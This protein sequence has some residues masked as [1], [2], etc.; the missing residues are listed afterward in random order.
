M[1]PIE[2]VRPT[3]EVKYS[4]DQVNLGYLN[5]NVSFQIQIHMYCT[6]DVL[7][8]SL[9]SLLSLFRSLTCVR[10][11]IRHVQSHYIQANQRWPL[12]TH[13]ETFISSS[14]SAWWKRNMERSTIRQIRRSTFSSGLPVTVLVFKLKSL[15]LSS[16]SQTQRREEHFGSAKL[17]RP[18]FC[19][20]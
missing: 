18:S 15:T 10:V 7:R 3:K 12:R 9:V 8:W 19:R 6:P 4:D 14:N 17:W 16:T 20:H 11:H 1:K 2:G 13:P 5:E